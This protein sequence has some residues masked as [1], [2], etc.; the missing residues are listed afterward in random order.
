M[1]TFPDL[2]S[3][4]LQALSASRSPSHTAKTKSEKKKAK[5]K[6]EAAAAAPFVGAAAPFVGEEAAEAIATPPRYARPSSGGSLAARCRETDSESHPSAASPTFEATIPDDPPSPAFEPTAGLAS[7]ILQSLGERTFGRPGQETS[8]WEQAIPFGISPLHR[9]SPP[10]EAVSR[11]PPMPSSPRL[12]YDDARAGFGGFSQPTSPRS[13]YRHAVRPAQQESPNLGNYLATSPRG[14][15]MSMPHQYSAA[16][17]VPQFAPAAGHHPSHDVSRKAYQS[18]SSSRRAP[19]YEFQA[20]DTLPSSE[21]STTAGVPVLVTSSLNSLYIHEVCADSLRYFGHFDGLRGSI[22]AAKILPVSLRYDRLREARPLIAVVVHGP[23]I[24]PSQEYDTGAQSHPDSEDTHALIQMHRPTLGLGAADNKYQTTVEVYSLKLRQCVATL[25][26]GPVIDVELMPGQIF[27]EAPPPVGSLSIE[28]KGRFVTVTSAVSGEVYIYETVRGDFTAPFRCIGKVWTSIPS[29]KHRTWSAS[30]TSVSSEVESNPDRSPS[31]SSTNVPILSLSSRWLAVVPPAPS[32]KSTLHGTVDDT[33]TDKSTPGLTAHTSGSHPSVNCELDA[34]FEES[35]INRAARDV[36]Q[37]FLKGAQW[38]GSQGMQA[39][40]NYWKKPE[41]PPTLDGS[42]S[43]S[44]N[45][46]FPPTHASDEASHGRQQLT[47]VTIFDLEKLS[48]AHDARSD[49][50][51]RPMAVFPLIDGCSFL[52]FGPTGL[53]LLTASTKGDVQY[54]WDL[55]RVPIPRSD[56]FAKTYTASHSTHASPII[57]QVARFTRV[58]QASIVDAAWA[59]PVG[60]KLAVLTERGTVHLHDL[61]STAFAWPP[62]RSKRPAGAHKRQSDVVPGASSGSVWAQ[63]SSA[64]GWGATL[65]SMTGRAQPILAAARETRMPSLSGLNIG[66]AG[67][68]AGVKGGKLV[69]S[70]FSKSVGAATGTVNSLYHMGENRLHIP[71]ATPGAI[72]PGTV[73]WLLHKDFEAVVVVGDGKVQ[74]HG[75]L[76]NSDLRGGRRRTSIV[77][78]RVAE[79]ALPKKREPERDLPCDGA[80]LAGYWP[81]APQQRPKSARATVSPFSHAELES[82]APFLPFHADGRVTL[83][84][85]DGNDAM[86][87]RGPEPWVFGQAIKTRDVPAATAHESDEGPIE[88]LGPMESFVK[89]TEPL[90]DLEPARVNTSTKR[91]K[92]KKEQ[93]LARETRTARELIEGPEDNESPYARAADAEEQP[94]PQDWLIGED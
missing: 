5:R 43:P 18:R 7:P 60:E 11:S 47:V 17:A 59:E 67:A 94:P 92:S 55:M 62:L 25:Y 37:E 26:R 86:L 28:T 91:K 56:A 79:H 65:S 66:A 22:L 83:S 57:R 51:M 32:S 45:P 21:D 61:P 6:H 10:V 14:R 40:K 90:V 54:V 70:G 42:R 38:V 58:T 53:M 76:R 36:T 3:D 52:S 93:A 20:F 48:E 64:S 33:L 27:A 2:L 41:D 16:H 80:T 77:G 50:A 4:D 68:G 15:P 81:S 87:D 30:S 8:E 89:E 74:I 24:P 13:A 85:L 35:R 63:S 31:S 9:P 73:R 23:Y 71:S 49:T 1:P 84:I 72:K 46:Q 34:P 19:H 82:A 12:P 78:P 39:W 88:A 69:A 75:V 29:R 44:I